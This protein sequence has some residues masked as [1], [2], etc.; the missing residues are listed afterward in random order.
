MQA[1][2]DVNKPQDVDVEISAK[3][4]EEG[5]KRWARDPNT[6]PAVIDGRLWLCDDYQRSITPAFVA[7]QRLQNSYNDGL[8]HHDQAAYEYWMAHGPT[9]RK[10]EPPFSGIGN[11]PQMK[12]ISNPERTHTESGN[13][14][15]SSL[16]KN[17]KN[18]LDS[19]SNIDLL[20]NQQGQ[21]STPS[22]KKNEPMQWKSKLSIGESP[23]QAAYQHW[24][25][26][27]ADILDSKK[28]LSDAELTEPT[29]KSTELGLENE[30]S[31]N[32]PESLESE[33]KQWKDRFN[34]GRMIA[35]MDKIKQK[36]R[37]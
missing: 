36:R 1:H 27:Q 8:L 17:T 5:G 12:S 2:N 14:S 11:T 10:Y 24:L 6:V 37:D 4:L 15:K 34:V 21:Q 18:I 32:I 26:K 20:N 19:G 28:M 29:A 31:M 16:E 30:D 3:W 22:S 13:F 7:K 35:S 25:S 23:S 33:L 9:P